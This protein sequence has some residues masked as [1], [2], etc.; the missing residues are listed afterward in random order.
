MPHETR[1]LVRFSVADFRFV[2]LRP[3]ELGIVPVSDRCQMGVRSVSD[4]W[5]IGGR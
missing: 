1:N 2:R 3:R 4:R 5:Q